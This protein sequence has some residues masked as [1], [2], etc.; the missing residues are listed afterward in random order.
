MK[1]F[2]RYMLYLG[3][4]LPLATFAQEVVK[5]P[6]AQRLVPGADMVRMTNRSGIPNYIHFAE[7]ARPD[8]QNFRNWIGNTLRLTDADGFK[9]LSA[10][11]D[12]IGMVHYRFGQTFQGQPV[13]GSMWIVHTLNGKVVSMNGDY[14]DGVATPTQVVLPESQALDR[15]LQHVGANAYKWQLPEEEKFIKWEQEDPNAT[16]FPKGQIVLVPENG[17]FIHPRFVCAWK[18]DIYAQSPLSRTEVFVDARNGNIVWERNR[19][20]HV[21]ST[22]SAVTG[23]SGT[24]NIKADWTGTTFR[25]RETG[26][27]QGIETYDMN[28]GTSYGAAVDFTDANNVWTNVNAQLD[29][30]ATDAHWGAEM[31]YDY[32]WLE[33]GRNSINGSGFRLRSYVHY[34]VAYS[35][36]F[37][38]GT[39][40]TYGDGNNRPFQALDVAGHE[41]THGLTTFTA[42]LVYQDEPGA[43]NESFS[44][45]FGNTIERLYRSNDWNWRIGED[46]YTNGI[47]N[48]QTPGSLGDPDTYFGT[49]WYTGTGDN[50]G[51]HTNS[52]VQNK[53]F[54]ILT[55][56][57]TGTNDIGSAYSV[58]GI[59]IDKASD[60]AYRNLTVYLSQ[61]SEYADAR[62][63]SIQSALDL[64]GPCSNEVTQT[65]NAWYAVGIG[66]QFNPTGTPNFI[67]SNT[68]TCTGTIFFSDASTSTGTA[69]HWNFGDGQTDTTQNP[70]H[71][72]AN[73]GTYSVTMIIT[74]CN[75]QDTVVRN[76]Y[77][78]V[79]RPSGPTG[80]GASRCG[81][82]TLTLSATGTGTVRW[83][84]APTGGSPL[85]TGTSFTT[86]SLASTTTYYAELETAQPST[87]FGPVTNTSVGGGGYHNNTSTQYLNFDVLAPVKLVSAKVYAG[88]AGNRT[89]QVWDNGGTL[90]WDTTLFIPNGTSR[91]TLNHSFTPGSYRIGGSN[92]NLWRNNSGPVYPYS[93]SG[94]VSIT[95][96]SAGASFYYYLYDWEIGEDPCRSVRT[97]VVATIAAATATVTASGP[98]TICPGGS[99]TLTASPN[100]TYQ[101]S[102]GATTQ[103]INVTT[104]GTFTVTVTN[105]SGCTGTSTATTVVV[106][107][108]PTPTVAAS[109]STALC[110]GSNVTLTASQGSTYMWSNGSTAQAITVS[111]AGTYTVTVS[112]PGGC[113][114]TATQNVTA[115]SAPN[116]TIN[117]SAGTNLCTG[118]SAT[119]TA[120]GGTQYAWSNGGSTAA[121]NVTAAGTYTVTVTNA[122]GCTDTETITL[123]SVA[124]PN[125]GINTP[126]TT[127]CQGGSA[128]LTGT[129]GGTYAWSTGANTSAI[130]VSTSGTYS[131]TVTAANGCTDVET[132]T[133][134]QI[135]PPA[136]SFTYTQN[137]SLVSF[138]NSSTGTNGAC[139]YAW[140]FGDG[141]TASSQ[142]PNHNY[143]GQ[144]PFTV[145]L[146]VNCQGC[147]DT[148]VQIVDLATGIA[149]G[150]AGVRMDIYPNPFS[151]NLH[152]DLG[153]T[154]NGLL[155][156]AMVDALGRSVTPIYHGEVAAGDL[157]L[158]WN[159]PS[160]LANGVYFAQI[161]FNGG[162]LRKKVILAR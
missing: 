90:L 97:P 133:M 150:L 15:A 102:N 17:S 109:G 77:V 157:K 89:I 96:S 47:R 60:I 59:G 75:G 152:F 74:T 25:L 104:A 53:W 6:A 80:T 116:A 43:L 120:G 72:Y 117:S 2:Q 49:N 135:A 161:T 65:T 23:Y 106:T 113:T 57:E 16:F 10:E 121:I 64:Y 79:A 110:P 130:T 122:N 114:G 153:L 36:A 93:L 105:G 73:N 160:Q 103:S 146:I 34:D 137:G 26:R 12:L 94:K 99:V 18:F 3:L 81:P 126:S 22:G 83:Y 115:A 159:A 140:N 68:T 112:Y 40:M 55:Q 31:T 145:T 128:V 50:G 46:L 30:Y 142:F 125:A 54:F 107:S 141:G 98:T 85:A 1:R 138:S 86:P 35:N 13:E 84:A 147:A 19:L 67:A 92:M 29:Q 123:T 88:A 127:F 11:Q 21:D 134:S 28:T 82:G 52:G 58:S 118:T 95:G 42:D 131:V 149:D 119:L 8:F 124:S 7:S 20:H 5:G 156:I 56:G 62:F 139:S 70:S 154:Q 9:L 61:N 45:I 14:F 51:V 162:T 38:D 4:F 155:D 48:M 87:F 111:G 78:T 63:Y 136:A 24:R 108:N 37:W 101:W 151:G 158:E 66:S 32:F 143:T 71:T 39:R 91:V 132:V 69:W 129:G 41:I 44:D 76:S 144:G 33:Q 100:S 27:G 148:I